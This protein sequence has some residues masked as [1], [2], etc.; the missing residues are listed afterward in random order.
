MNRIK[1]TLRLLAAPL[2]LASV[3]VLMSCQQPS[4]HPKAGDVQTYPYVLRA[5]DGRSMHAQIGR[6]LVPENRQ[7][8]TTRLVEIAFVRVKSTAKTPGPPILLVAGGPGS[9]GID[10]PRGPM[11]DFLPSLLEVADVVA[12]DQ[13][14]IGLSRPNLECAESLGF[15]LESVRTRE[16]VMQLVRERQRACAAFFTS[17]GVDLAGYTTESS[18]DDIDDLR[19]AIGAVKVTLLGGSYGSHLIFS[20]LRRHGA[21][22]HKAIITGTEGPD[23]TVKLPSNEQKELEKIGQLVAADPKLGKFIP[24]F[25][26]LVR[27]VLDRLEKQPVTVEAIDPATRRKVKVT[28]SKFDLQIITAQ[29]LGAS[30]FIQRLPAA[31]YDMSRGDFSWLAD[32]VITMQRKPI[33]SAMSFQMDCASGI[34]AE[35]I[36]QVKREAAVTLLGDVIDLPIPDACD[37]AVARDLGQAFR[38]PLRTDVPALFLSGTIDGRTPPPNAEEIRKGFSTSAH[39]ITANAAHGAKDLLLGAKETRDAAIAFLKGTPVADGT[40]ALPPL[41]FAWPNTLP[42]PGAHR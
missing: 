42:R 41:E 3:A 23:H 32:A 8:K 36:A 18:A 35:R 40:A 15:P 19:T 2:V 6:V 1:A 31:Y 25:V 10:I 28:L 7:A 33:E 16:S 17:H 34:S 27:T 21:N 5:T 4:P 26:G 39:I 13:R 22:I 24:D 38:G 14:G 30:A 12:F 11:F 9:S 20:T 29:G 37:A